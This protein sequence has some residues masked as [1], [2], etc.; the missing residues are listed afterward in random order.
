MR[1][2]SYNIFEG[3]QN[4]LP[5]LQSFVAQQNLDVLCIQEANGWN[6]GVPSR[7]ENFAVSTGL[8]YYVYGDSNTRF[9]LV[10]L[11]RLPIAHSKVYT[12]GFWHSAVRAII[13]LGSRT[14][15]LWN[16]HLN[17]NDEDSR[18]SEVKRLSAM[19]DRTQ[20]TIVSGDFNS[21]SETDGYS[22]L[23]IE[24][25]ALQ[26]IR[27]F[28]TRKL[29]YDVTNYIAS[30][31]L[32]DLAAAQGQRQTTVPTSANNDTHHAADIRVDYMFATPGITN[33][34]EEIDVPKDALTNIISDH[35]PLVLTLNGH[36]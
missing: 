4:T 3:A 21:L 30:Q 26:G 13:R 35:Y 5:E 18:L 20:P 19:I 10:T 36:V 25:L 12:E 29:R 8:H 7:L 15:D 11:S 9:K 22:D 31:G 6:N 34:I 2:A 24:N 32:V 17:P 1:I 23:L 28:G 16:V 14:L 33:L 27:K